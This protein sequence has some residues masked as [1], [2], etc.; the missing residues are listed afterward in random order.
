M[1]LSFLLNG[2]EVHVSSAGPQVTLLDFIRERGLTG[3]KEGCAE[4]ECGA[5]AVAMVAGEQGRS[6]YRVVNSCLMFL[7]MA[8]DREFYTVE[9]LA[10]RGELSDVQQAMAAAGGSQCGYCTP[11]FVMSLFAEQY[12]RDRQGSCD[13]LA[14]AGN[15]CR[16]TGY[17]PIRDA[18]YA[19]GPAL[20]GAFLDRLHLPPPEL[21]RVM[22]DGFSRPTTLDECVATLRAIPDATLIA[23]CTDLGVEANLRQKRWT[24]LVSVEAV[25]ELH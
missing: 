17:R 23:G 10:G 16:C 3:A 12:R 13:P 4:G 14:M 25:P 9:S 22:V 11:G 7:P 1:A 19:V 21:D 8:A 15:L 2:R 5:C 18:A 24:H 6:A 20:A